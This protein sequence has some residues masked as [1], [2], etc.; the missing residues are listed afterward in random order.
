MAESLDDRPPLEPSSLT[1]YD[2]EFN[3]VEKREDA[4]WERKFFIDEEDGE[5][6]FE[7][8]RINMEIKEE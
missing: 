7:T 5:P 4:T 2:K 1:Y 3:P 6:T 8:L